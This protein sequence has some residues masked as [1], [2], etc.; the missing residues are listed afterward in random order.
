MRSTRALFTGVA[1]AAALALTSPGVAFAGS[2]NQ[3]EAKVNAQQADGGHAPSDK[4]EEHKKEEE[5]KGEEHKAEEHKAEEHK[6]DEERKGEERKGE[7]PQ[8]EHRHPHGGIH[9]GGGG[10]AGSGTNLTG[11]VVLLLGGLGVGAYALRR[12]QGSLG[13]L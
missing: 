8:K 2:P 7:D 3:P 13:A 4:A 9:A 10:L 12:R 6:K 11:G 1:V 5:R